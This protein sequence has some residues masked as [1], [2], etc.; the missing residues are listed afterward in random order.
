MKDSHEKYVVTYDVFRRRHFPTFVLETMPITTKEIR[1]LPNGGQ[2]L[3]IVYH[4]YS[5]LA[6]SQT[7]PKTQSLN[8]F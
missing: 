5:L 8:I 4:Y 2:T 6:I 3:P 7:R 1:M